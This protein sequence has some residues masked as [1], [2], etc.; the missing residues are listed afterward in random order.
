LKPDAALD[1]LALFG[2]ALWHRKIIA[3]QRR[4]PVH[5]GGSVKRG[6]DLPAKT[7]DR[8]AVGILTAGWRVDQMNASANRCFGE[9]SGS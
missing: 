9:M 7:P 4:S 3:S 2:S 5:L 6:C 8:K 1:N